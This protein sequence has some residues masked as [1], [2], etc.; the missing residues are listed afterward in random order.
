M[1]F[2]VG[3]VICSFLSDGENLCIHH[4]KH[5]TRKKKLN[6]QKKNVS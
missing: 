4:L 5:N 1:A 6:T 2:G 3:A